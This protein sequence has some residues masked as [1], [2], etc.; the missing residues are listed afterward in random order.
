MG[1][2]RHMKAKS[3]NGKF[4]FPLNIKGDLMLPDFDL[5]TNFQSPDIKNKISSEVKE[6]EPTKR[7]KQKCQ[8]NKLI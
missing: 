4:K 2:D 3:N 6:I 5:S 7:K 1:Y 8:S